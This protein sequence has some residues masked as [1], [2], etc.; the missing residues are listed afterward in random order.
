M[1]PRY[2]FTLIELLVAIAIISIL[3]VAGF[4]SYIFSIQK[5]RDAQR[6]SDLATISKALEVFANDFGQYPAVSSGE[7]VACDTTGGGLVACDWGEPMAAYVGGALQTYL[8]KLPD[9]PSSTKNYR[10]QR[11]GSSYNLY[12]ALENAND[13]N[14]KSG[15]TLT[16]G[17]VT[18]LC[19]YQ[20]DP[21][22]IVQ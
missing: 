9:D 18:I 21:S 11:V 17:S 10:Y 22:G 3:A 6:K 12:A 2:G 1:K 16:C 20:R 4:T 19:N 13:P 8:A 5:A 14:V 7:M 15:I